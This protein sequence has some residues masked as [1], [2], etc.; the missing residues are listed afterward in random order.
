[1]LRS[2]I[3]GYD[4]QHHRLGYFEGKMLTLGGGFRVYNAR[5]TGVADIKGHWIGWSFCFLDAGSRALGLVTKKWTGVGRE[6]FPAADNYL[7]LLTDQGTAQPAT[8]ALLLAAGLA[9][10]TRYKEARSQ[11]TGTST[12]GFSYTPG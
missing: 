6:L 7:I 3:N 8:T 9:I 10:D 5:G 11:A 1:L 2:K 12:T 4:G